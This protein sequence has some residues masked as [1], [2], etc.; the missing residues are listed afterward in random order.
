MEL[1]ESATNSLAVSYE[2][3]YRDT[4]AN[5]HDALVVENIN[6]S[7]IRGPFDAPHPDICAIGLVFAEL[8]HCPERLPA[9][10]DKHLVFGRLCVTVH[11]EPSKLAAAVHPHGVAS[12]IALVDLE[13]NQRRRLKVFRV[14]NRL[15]HALVGSAVV[16][17]AGEELVYDARRHATVET[18]IGLF[19]EPLDAPLNVVLRTVPALEPD[20]GPLEVK[21]GLGMVGSLISLGVDAVDGHACGFAVR[22]VEDD[23]DSEEHSWALFVDQSLVNHHVL[24][25]YSMVLEVRTIFFEDIRAQGNAKVCVQGLQKY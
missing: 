18:L 23:I 10:I 9:M 19:F 4:T 6:V 20:L 1:R 14:D 21:A 11:Q 25:V 15:L 3:S 22:H 16:N 24:D 7:G 5:T 17:Q 2:Q 13:P 12:E 8:P